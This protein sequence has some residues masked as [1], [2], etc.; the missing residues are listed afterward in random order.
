MGAKSLDGKCRSGIA[1]ST[2]EVLLFLIAACDYRLLWCSARGL[3]GCLS[4]VVFIASFEGAEP[5]ICL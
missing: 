4:A 3:A 2:Q 5:V 1:P